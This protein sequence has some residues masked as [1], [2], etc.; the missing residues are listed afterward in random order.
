M[1]VIDWIGTALVHLIFG[2]FFVAVALLAAL[3]TVSYVLDLIGVI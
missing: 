3:I 2:A 1:K